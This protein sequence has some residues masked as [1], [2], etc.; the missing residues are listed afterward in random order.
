MDTEIEINGYWWLPE[1]P[2]E[3]ISGVLSFSPGEPILLKLMGT[4]S[5][6]D[7]LTTTRRDFI[8][9]LIIYGMSLRGELVTLEGCTQIEGTAGLIGIST[10]SFTGRFVYIGVHF[11]SEKLGKFKG[12]SIR[13]Q[14][15]DEW[16]CKSAFKTQNLS[17]E[18]VTVTYNQPAPIKTIVE[19]YHIDFVVVGPNSSEDYFTHVN[20][21]Q[22]ACINIWSETE[23][24]ISEFMPLIRHIQNFLTLAMSSPTYVTEIIGSTES[25]KEED[26]ALYYPIK[27]YYLATSWKLNH[28]KKHYF[29]MMF[30]LPTVEEQ[31]EKILA[32]W[33]SNAEIIKP[34][35]D[36]Y[37]STLYNS[38]IYQEFQFLSLA[39]AVET[40]HRQ[41]YGGKYQ[42]NDVFLNGL[43][44][45]LVAAIPGDVNDD[46]RSS[47]KG[48]KL[49]YANE[50]SLRKRLLELGKHIAANDLE[51]NFL[52]D[53]EHRGLFAENV[54]NTRNYFTH[55]P[56]EL[57]GIAA[58]GGD[59]LRDLIRKLRLIIQICFLEQLGFPFDKIKDIFKKKPEYRGYFLK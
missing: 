27:I 47:L 1:T 16:F 32:K 21:S 2:N 57:K 15:L 41:V 39:Q 11:T 53:E 3:Q 59:D 48:G 26:P 56:D 18:S 54:T 55:Y 52:Y 33:L 9:P 49:R 14:D 43:Y 42:S 12:V 28:S 36:L 24:D 7:G 45:V 30:T 51:L 34:V 5:E 37:F 29:E 20:L 13:F 22:K 46:F 44:K 40:Y 17:A 6:K 50:Y 38:S 35:Y 23:K 31:I 58:K 10:T 25:A 19:G 4:L 8:N